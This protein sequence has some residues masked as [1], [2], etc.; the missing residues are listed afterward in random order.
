MVR[1][2]RPSGTATREASLT[3]AR[4]RRSAP[5]GSQPSGS[6]DALT[7]DAR[8]LQTSS[9][10]MR[11]RSNATPAAVE[12]VGVELDAEAL[13]LP[14]GVQL[15]ALDEGVHRRSRQAGVA[16]RAARNRRSSSDRVNA[17]SRYIGDRAASCPAPTV[18]DR[19]AR[20]DSSTAR[21][22][23]S[24]K[25]SARS[26][27]RRRRRGAISARSSSVRGTAVTGIPSS[28]PRSSFATAGAVMDVNRG[29]AMPPGSG[30]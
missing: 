26:I 11:S 12:F 21:R 3:A 15:V 2:F 23:S 7:L 16:R 6:G 8:Q 29:A 22:S 14:V 18:A 17:G 9:S 30:P 10:R 19:S 13:G 27:A 4:S 25:R 5:R 28:I 24:P 20:S 1:T